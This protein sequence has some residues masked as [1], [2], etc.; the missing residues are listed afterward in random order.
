MKSILPLLLLS[1]LVLHHCESSKKAQSQQRQRAS[2]AHQIQFPAPDPM[3]EKLL[4]EINADSI[5]TYVEKLV[6]F[7][8]RHTLSDTLSETVGIGAARRWIFS[9]FERWNAQSGNKMKVYYNR[10]EQAVR[11]RVD[12]K[13]E[14]VNVVAE[15]PGTSESAKSRVYVVSGHYDS[16][17]KD[18]MNRIDFAP[19]AN[20]DASGTAAVMEMVR[21]MS[22]YDFEATLIFMAV[23]GEEQGLL[24]ARNFAE[25]AKNTGMD[26]QGMI[27]NDIM[28]NSRSDAGVINDREVRVFGEGIQPKKE[29]SDYDRFLLNTGGENDTPSRQLARYIYQ[30][31]LK[32]KTPVQALMIYRKDRYLR[33][34]DH[35]PF[36]EM[37]FP[38]VRFSEVNENFLYQHEDVREEN[39]IQYGDLIEF[40]DFTYLANVTRLNA[41]SLAELAL[42]PA[43]PKNVGMVT[44]ILENSTTL[45]WTENSEDDLAGYRIVWRRTIDP[46]WTN[47]MDV[48]KVT[49]FTVPKVSKDNYLFGVQAYDTKGHLS[50]AVYPLPVR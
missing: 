4:A 10:Y 41:A 3:V 11:P 46:H 43:A 12:E 18:V 37:G 6:G 30:T 24:G 16:R 35:S 36:L 13:T 48:G 31:G 26:I 7:H 44:S 2:E 40:M 5:R 21:I 50:P 20:D 34:G 49:R 1:T 27:T 42:A 29:L 14:I 38:A 32:Y 25:M 39:G 15:L 45:R 47:A 19:G 8:T 28:G 9:E 23:A 33:G 17:V 22:K